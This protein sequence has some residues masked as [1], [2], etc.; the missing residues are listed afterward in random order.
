MNRNGHTEAEFADR[1]G[2]DRIRELERE[3]SAEHKKVAALASR[4][5]RPGVVKVGGGAY[6]FGLFGD[7]HVGSLYANDRARDSYFR[8]LADNGIDTAY[9]TGDVLDGGGVYKGQEYELRDV[10]LARQ[11]KRLAGVDR[12]GVKVRFIAGNHDLSFKNVSGVDVGAVIEDA[13]DG[14]W[15][16]LGEEQAS[17]EFEVG[18]KNLS[19][20]LMHP[21]GGSSY[22]LCFD[23][24]TEIL[25]KDRGWQLFANLVPTDAVAT[26]RKDTGELEWQVP[27]EHV[28]QRYVGELIKF[29]G[30]H[31]DLCV[32]PEH[33]FWA[34]RP[35]ERWKS[36][37]H[38]G[39]RRDPGYQM[40]AA[41][42][43]R[44]RDWCIPKSATGWVGQTEF[45]APFGSAPLA[46]SELIGWYVAEGSRSKANGQIQIDQL[47]RGTLGH[48]AEL[49]R[50][51]GFNPYVR[52]DCGRIVVTH[53]GLYSWVAQHCP[54]RSHEKRIPRAILMSSQRAL[55]AFMVGYLRGD[56]TKT[57][58][59][60]HSCTT[61]SRG[62]AGDVQEAALKLG[63]S[64]CVK[65]QAGA[66]GRLIKGVR[67]KTART[68]FQVSFNYSI[69]E[70]AL[71]APVKRGYRGEVYCVRTDNEVI[72]VRRN[73]KA[74]RTGNSYRM[75]KI[76]ESLEGGTK[77]DLLAAGHFHKMDL[78]PSYRNVLGIQTG[79]M[80]DQ[81]PFM[82]RKGLAAN[83]GG[84]IIRIEPGDGHLVVKPEFVVFF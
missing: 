81:T 61:V 43:I 23:D 11:A 50:R 83:V 38:T 52:K 22:A 8:W 84:W 58:R 6:A 2:S 68:K 82:V 48:I 42:D 47:D 73:G 26:R 54:G 59:G 78:L 9:H 63:F 72:Y 12:H 14:G 60:W 18:K 46:F 56:G 13:T 3:L 19:M 74:C 35:W 64:A 15:E 10:G 67:I 20:M 80:Q 39:A 57:A 69:N 25:T 17:V 28:R 75:Q 44:G 4:R 70:P 51:C 40:V 1:H 21:G 32:T 34:R 77:P 76:I 5:A 79:T 36:S 66:P 30:H 62:L 65:E 33:R 49:A 71:C 41:K 37:K 29:K 31:Y 45:I 27:R 55:G 24:Q 16:S 53:R 7:T